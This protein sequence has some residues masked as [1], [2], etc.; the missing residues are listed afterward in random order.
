MSKFKVGDRVRKVAMSGGDDMCM[1]LNDMG[2][3]IDV[4][5]GGLRGAIQVKWDNPLAGNDWW[6]DE[7]TCEL[8]DKE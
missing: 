2:T 5:Y 4:G 1:R 3:V 7:E 8:E 6:T